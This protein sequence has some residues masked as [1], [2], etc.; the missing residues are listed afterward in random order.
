MNF[1]KKQ[2]ILSAFFNEAYGVFARSKHRTIER[3][4]YFKRGKQVK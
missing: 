4:D 1:N 3:E 2:I